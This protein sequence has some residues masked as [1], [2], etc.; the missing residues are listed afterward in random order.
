M[1]FTLASIV[2]YIYIFTVYPARTWNVNKKVNLMSVMAYL[3]SCPIV[4]ERAY[5]KCM[6][7]FICKVWC[8]ILHSSNCNSNFLSFAKR[9]KCI[10]IGCVVSFSN[11]PFPSWCSM[12]YTIYLKFVM[13]NDCGKQKDKIIMIRNATIGNA[14]ETTKQCDQHLFQVTF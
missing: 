9:K 10:Q 3:T 4:A 1:V 13:K 6:N 12:Y 7:N 2:L 8:R 11:W 5:N 14:C